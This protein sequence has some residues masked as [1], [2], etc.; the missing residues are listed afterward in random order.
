VLPGSA[1]DVTA[2]RD[3][4]PAVL[5]PYLGHLPVL[6]DDGYHGADRGVYPRSRSPGTD[7]NSTLT[8]TRI[9]GCYEACGAAL[10]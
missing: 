5:A 8:R 9:A 4:F 3:L 6:A 2:A 10:A 1:H 7:T